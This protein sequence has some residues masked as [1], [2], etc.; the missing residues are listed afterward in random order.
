MAPAVG[1]PW[2]TCFLVLCQGEEGR[3]R[4]QFDCPTPTTKS[5]DFDS[6]GIAKCDLTG[7]VEQRYTYNVMSEAVKADD[8]RRG[9]PGIQGQFALPYYT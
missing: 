5:C 1:G 9:K 2:K 6:K 8:T 4:L 3:R 7:L